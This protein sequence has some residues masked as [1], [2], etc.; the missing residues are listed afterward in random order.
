M[1]TKATREAVI[2]AR[3]QLNENQEKVTPTAIH[4]ITGG[5]KATIYKLLAELADEDLTNSLNKPDPAVDDLVNDVTRELVVKIYSYC[6]K[7]ADAVAMA[8]YR[9]KADHEAEA[10]K[11]LDR[12]DNI[13]GEYEA[14]ETALTEKIK[15]LE[16]E[17]ALLQE[18]LKH[19]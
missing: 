19:K 17:I 11:V 6:K 16:A 3:K 7:R 13:E 8:E 4:R 14:K 12:L 18:K 2:A 5:S 1:K 15:R 9:N 10:L